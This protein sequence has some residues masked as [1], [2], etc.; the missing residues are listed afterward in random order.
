MASKTWLVRWIRSLASAANAAPIGHDVRA[1]G[2]KGDATTLCTRAIQN[3]I[4]TAAEAGGGTVF[5]PAGKFLTGTIYLKSNVTLMLEA[6]CTLLGSTDLKNYPVR[7]ADTRSYTDSYGKQSLISGEG[8]E[9]VAIVGRGTID[10]Q[11]KA[12]AWTRERPY[13]DRPYL[14]RLARCR[15]VLIEGVRLQNSAMWMQHYL[16]CERLTIRGITVHNHVNYNNDGLDIDS[17]EDVTVAQCVI[18]S[19][20][21]AIC[22]KSTMDRPCANVTISDCI[23]RSH[24]NAIK[25][26]TESSGGFVNITITNCVITSPQTERKYGLNRGLAGIALEIVDGGRMERVTVSSIAIQGV[27]VPIFMRLGNRARSFK[28]DTP[29]PGVGTMRNVILSDILATDVSPTGCAIS[30]VAGH[31]IEG[32][33]LSNIRLTFEGGGTAEQASRSIP[34]R[35]KDYPESLM[36]GPLPAY[37]L[38]CRHVKEIKL[39]NVVL[40]TNKADLRHA[41]VCDD[42]EDVTIDG[43][44]AQHSPGAASLVRLTSSRDVMIRGS[45]PR[46][47]SGT[48]LEVEGNDTRD[49]VLMGN[50][51]T[52][53]GKTVEAATEEQQDAVSQTANRS[54]ATGSH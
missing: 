40:R 23:A 47:P 52:Q 6:G 14:I 24:C 25:M 45:K 39:D 42:A 35:E 28:K 53:V 44:D 36:F 34:E 3:A 37:G 11:G 19:D 33:T 46:A 10:G 41:V 29:P 16:A 5:F 22:L 7:V 4:D 17:C 27:S 1:H 15:D 26:G 12:F 50:D 20:D 49:V 9:N 21:D 13:E 54:R 31:A 51:L 38:Y 8:L 32:V 43:L 48:F 2:A 18:D 30:G